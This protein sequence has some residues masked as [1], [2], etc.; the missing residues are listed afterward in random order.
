MTDSAADIDALFNILEREIQELRE[1]SPE[2]E[3]L[4]F[5]GPVLENEDWIT[6]VHLDFLNRFNPTG[7]ASWAR[8][9][10]NYLVEIRRALG[11]IPD[12]QPAAT[13][14]PPDS[15]IEQEDIPF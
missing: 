13:S 7:Q 8:Q 12:V 3:L 1:L 4:K 6:E 15:Q 11:R 5:A 9:R 10:R 2:H 14:A